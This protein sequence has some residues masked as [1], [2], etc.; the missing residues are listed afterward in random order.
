MF[1]NRYNNEQ[2]N[3]NVDWHFAQFELLMY[4]NAGGDTDYGMPFIFPLCIPYTMY[5]IG[6]FLTGAEKKNPE[7][8]YEY[9]TYNEYAT[10][11]NQFAKFL[12]K[13]LK[14]DMKGQS[15]YVQ[16]VNMYSKYVQT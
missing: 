14:K 2:S 4:Y 8:S 10:D 7:S 13:E 12:C 1:C 16:T 15:K 3:K 6:I 5:R 9:A 11:E